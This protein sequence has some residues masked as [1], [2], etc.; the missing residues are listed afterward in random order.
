MADYIPPNTHASL[1]IVVRQNT[2]PLDGATVTAKVF[3]PRGVVVANDVPLTGLGSGSGAYV[4]SI[5]NTW[6][7]SSGK[8]VEG[9]YV[10]EITAVSG[11]YT[12]TNRFRYTVRFDDDS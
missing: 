5:T 12:A 1:T 6:S 4:L 9:E 8:Y 2:A 10:A 7:V 3:S 11:S